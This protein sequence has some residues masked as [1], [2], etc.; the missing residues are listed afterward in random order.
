M[1][2]FDRIVVMI[3]RSSFV[4]LCVRIGRGQK[5]HL[6]VMQGILPSVTITRVVRLK[7]RSRL[8]TWRF[9]LDIYFNDCQFF[10]K[11]KARRLQNSRILALYKRTLLLM[12]TF[13]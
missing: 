3:L 11:I 13:S 6:F 2:L 8:K 12:N 5:L 1:R 4:Y 10:V 9:G 7:I